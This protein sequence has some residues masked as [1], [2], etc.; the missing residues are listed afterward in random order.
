MGQYTDHRVMALDK[1]HVWLNR[2][3]TPIDQL[4][5]GPNFLGWTRPSTTTST[6]TSVTTQ[7]APLTPATEPS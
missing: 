5:T 2:Q 4:E 3:V 6:L 7:P 1:D